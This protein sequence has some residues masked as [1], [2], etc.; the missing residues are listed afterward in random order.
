MSRRAFIT[1]GLLIISILVV[2]S[3]FI[4]LFGF[5]QTTVI[6]VF[7]QSD[8]GN[9]TLSMDLITEVNSRYQ[10]GFDGAVV[11]LAGILIVGSALLAFIVPFHPIFI[12]VGIVALFPLLYIS[13]ILTEV[14]F[15]VTNQ[16]IL[17][18]TLIY[19]SRNNIVMNNL[20]MIGLI[21]DTVFLAIM[22]FK[23]AGR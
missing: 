6:G 12:V 18:E 4:V 9:S 16:T 17:N 5:I 8:I 1:D 13:G 3:F 11:F 23:G 19:Y 7:N 21:A 20:S 2:I 14:F 15:A 22:F 10:A